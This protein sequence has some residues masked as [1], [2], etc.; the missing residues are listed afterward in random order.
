[1]PSARAVGLST[2]ITSGIVCAGV[3]IAGL[4]LSWSAHRSAPHPSTMSFTATLGALAGATFL[5]VIVA[6]T[7]AG[8][9]LP[10]CFR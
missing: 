10:G 7:M 9:L 2:V 3:A 4:L 8:F 6:G 1:M 5:L